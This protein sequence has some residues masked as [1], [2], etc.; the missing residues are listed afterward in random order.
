MSSPAGRSVRA[1]SDIY[2]EPAV[3]W[4]VR[5]FGTHTPGV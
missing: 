2:T 5:F 1:V 3:E 4:Q